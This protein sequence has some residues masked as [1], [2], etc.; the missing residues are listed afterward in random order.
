M[1]CAALSVSA[2]AG[3]EKSAPPAPLGIRVADWTLPR[4]D[5]GKPW[6]LAKD[7]RDA[8]AVVVVFI[9]TECPVSNAYQPTLAAL[10]K[11]Y[12][13]EDVLFV[14][15]NSNRQDDAA[16]VAKHA[17]EHAIPFTVLK[18]DGVTV[19]DRF[20]AKRTPEAFVLDGTRTVRYR[21][22]I[23]DQFDRSVKRVQPDHHELAD[24]LDAVLAGR[25]VTRTATEPSGCVITR[26]R[27]VAAAKKAVTYSKEVARILQNN[28][29]ECHRPGEAAPF[30]LMNYADAANWA[31]P[32]RE[33]VT[34]QRMPPWNADRAHGKFKNA[35][36]LTDAD[37]ADL[38]AWI[39]ADCPEG[40]AAD[41]PK[42]RT[43]ET[44]WRIG[45]PDQV[46]SLTREVQIPAEAPEGGMRYQYILVGEPFK[47]DKW[48]KAVEARPS[49][50]GVVHHIIV[51]VKPPPKR[52]PRPEAGDLERLFADFDGRNPDDFGQFFLAA[53][54]P[55]DSP[56]IFPEG[57]GKKIAKGSQL[58]FEM[59]YT[60]NG[61]AGVDRSSVGL[62]Y[63]D[64]AP[65]HEI[66]TRAISNDRFLIPP[67]AS[68]HKIVSKTTF[69]RPAVLLSLAPHMH[70][71][72]KSFSFTLTPPDGKPEMMLSV[73]KYDFNWQMSYILSEPRRVEKGTKLDCVG[74]YDNSR[75]NPNNPN[76]WKPVMWGNQTWDEMMIGF[77][78]YYYD[79]AK[80]APKSE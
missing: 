79:D 51:F 2:R 73:P 6:S 20:S 63:S 62:V 16:A 75:A 44:G 71:R 52:K 8:K 60:P 21:G 80:P 74:Y 12:S 49:N 56:I 55:G 37:R 35:R 57:M 29:Q 39:D 61:Q 36:G 13:A 47:E 32:I 78:D 19:A 46:F 42:P 31:G 28:C 54:V 72:G 64:K 77:V 34:E 69:D 65:E 70:L 26:P 7:G 30:K 15:I 27:K 11:K 43:Y 38:L 53:Y 33:A 10:H 41:L 76:P 68:D 66:H 3:D 24:A 45:K 22:R 4:A 18:D 59:H 50:R 14:A 58:F 17:K 5:D 1:I 25:D 9:G 67:F 23:D 40:T 48:V